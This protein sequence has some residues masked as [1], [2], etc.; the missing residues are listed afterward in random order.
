MFTDSV[1]DNIIDQI[2]TKL[3]VDLIRI[4][5]FDTI[6]QSD[7]IKNNELLQRKILSF[8]APLGIVLRLE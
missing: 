6:L 7:N 8:S 3:N 2:R 4:S 1:T 5:P